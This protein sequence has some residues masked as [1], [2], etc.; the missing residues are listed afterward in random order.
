ML[1]DEERPLH[2]ESLV[3][4]WPTVSEKDASLLMSTQDSLTHNFDSLEA[5]GISSNKFLSIVD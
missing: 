3:L 2:L 4:E 5:I 1:E